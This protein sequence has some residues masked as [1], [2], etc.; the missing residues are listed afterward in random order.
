MD[1]LAV[2]KF[3]PQR[4]L[5]AIRR[6]GLHK[7]AGALR[8]FDEITLKEAAG[9]L[10]ARA[11]VRRKEASAIIEGIVAFAEL[12]GEKT[13]GNLTSEL[14]HRALAPAAFGAGIA[15][16]PDLMADG[17][18]DQNKMLQHA[19]IG[20]GIGLAGGAGNAVRRATQND[21][22]LAEHLVQALQN[23]PK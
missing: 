12:R 17:P 4:A 13:A 9:L 10:G 3:V 1:N 6:A 8:G 2:E 20:G 18:V 21:P 11:Y 7:V 5:D 23:R 16:I 19:L 15:T 22:A 14:L